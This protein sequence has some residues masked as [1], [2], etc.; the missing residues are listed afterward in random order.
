MGKY[1]LYI[2][3]LLLSLETYS[4]EVD[5]LN[6]NQI[7][8]QQ[9]EG[10]SEKTT[11]EKDFS[12]IAE[13]LDFLKNNKINLNTASAEDLK[14]LQILDIF[15]INNL[16]K[17]RKRN[18]DFLSLFEL[19][20]IQGFTKEI[21]RTITPYISV[22]AISE[23]EKI[24]LKELFKY[25]NHQLISRFQSL[26][27]T[28]KGYTPKN[29]TTPSKYHGSKHKIYNRYLFTAS[30]KIRFGFTLEKDSGE[31]FGADYTDIGF[32]FTSFHLEVKDIGFVKKVI[33]G[34]YHL[35]FGQGL[36]LWSSFSTN[37]SVDATNI[38]RLGRGVAPFTGANENL[39][40]RGA[41][42]QLE[43]EN[44]LI[45]PFYSYNKI[46]ASLNIF[47]ERDEFNTDETGF[48][49]TDSEIAKRNTL[50]KT[51]FGAD[52]SYTLDALKFGV[53]AFN[54]SYDNTLYGGEQEYQLF[55]FSGD[56]QSTV[57]GHYLWN[58]NDVILS[59]EHS[60]NIGGSWATI[61][62]AS[63]NPAPE[64]SFVL[65]YRNYQKD[66]FSATNA[67]FS[68]YSSSG[69]VGYYFGVKSELHKYLTI[70][71]YI[72][73][74]SKTWLQFQKD[75]P[76]KGFETL[77]Q[78]DTQLNRTASAYFRLKYEKK[79]RN[80]YSDTNFINQLGEEKKINVRLHFNKVVNRNLRLSSRAEI[81]KYSLQS[82]STGWLIYQD[83]KWKFDNSPLSLYGRV[84]FFDIDNWNNR[85]YAYEND[86]SYIFSVPA[87]Y[88]KGT[89]Y[90]LGASYK[91][92]R[93]L[94]F[95][96]R[97][98]LTS[99]ENVDN[100][101]SGNDEIKGNEKSEIKLQMRIKL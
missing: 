94:S 79:N 45:S 31:E 34:D 24:N 96:C 28:P 35:E 97:V 92:N 18:G 82:E 40:F 7:F 73:V 69:E 75:A 32:D 61:H 48:H 52:V 71:G 95:W 9:I 46:D 44:L 65:S 74:F 70:S 51:D 13:N 100:I 63:I 68:E 99:F 10:I 2:S 25:S 67:P 38:V 78:F 60:T 4:Q 56:T 83:V 85:I 15:Q 43:F 54:T 33:V 93:N 72:D 81:S 62:N 30:N 58:L 91:L 101:G 21:V 50:L 39:F 29:D 47:E 89:R 22:D 57:S 64:L 98:S 77:L 76:A 23:G 49:R 55:N 37:K 90:Y 11:G 42:A 41:S 8:E 59:G 6:A 53:T 20:S 16:L 26:V 1:I 86:I 88:N 17:Y 3:L 84:A 80:I 12:E 5:S 66:Y 27:Q 19:T 14:Q 36:A 87:Y